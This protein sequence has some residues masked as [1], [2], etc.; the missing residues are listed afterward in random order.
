M[1]LT[2]TSAGGSCRHPAQTPAEDVPV[3]VEHGLPRGLAHVDDDAVVV[4]A[5]L[6][7][8]LGDE[9][10]HSRRLLGRKLGDL[11]ERVDVPLGEDEQVRL[12]LRVDVLDRD[13]AV[14][15]P[16]V[17]AILD[18]PTEEAI[19]RQRARPPR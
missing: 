2:R 9:G 1:R 17:R 18:E 5:G 4:E 8:R 11:A 6:A 12:G 3:E 10:Q 16:L 14:A 19:V 7:G 13:E 15:A